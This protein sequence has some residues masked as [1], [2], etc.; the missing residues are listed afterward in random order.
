MNIFNI[1]R[2]KSDDESE[3]DDIKI[4]FGFKGEGLIYR[5][6][7][8]KIYVEFTWVNGSR[9]Y[10]DEI[11]KWEDGS[12]LTQSEKE[13]VFIDLLNFVGEK[14]GKPIVVINKDDASKPLWE[15][16]CSSNKSLIEKIEYTSDEEHFQ[17]NR[18]LGLDALKSG[19][20]IKQI[21][22][23]V[24]IKNE[25]DLDRALAREIKKKREQLD[26]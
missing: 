24:E 20:K 11:K 13:K 16:L 19:G 17:F 10:P 1:F 4:E 14:R 8:R 5:Q 2:R 9:I 6:A 21:I 12:K 3:H 25:Q 22:D 18:K 23:G 7:R 26:N 15:D